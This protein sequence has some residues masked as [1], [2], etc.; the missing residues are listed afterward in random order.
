MINTGMIIWEAQVLLFSIHHTLIDL[1]NPGCSS[2]NVSPIARFVRPLASPLPADINRQGS[3]ARETTVIYR[4]R[5]QRIT[6][7]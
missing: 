6:R 4:A 5:S 3:A 7:D 2:H 1:Q